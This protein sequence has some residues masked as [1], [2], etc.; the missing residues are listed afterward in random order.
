[1]KK[2]KRVATTT[3]LDTIAEVQEESKV[4]DIEDLIRR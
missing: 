1:M 4:E 3:K 2:S